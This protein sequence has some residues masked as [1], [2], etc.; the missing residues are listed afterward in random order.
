MLSLSGVIP[1]EGHVILDR[2]LVRLGAGQ[3]TLILLIQLSLVALYVSETTESQYV[4]QRLVDGVLLVDGFTSL[5][6][7]DKGLVVWIGERVIIQPE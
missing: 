1:E 5:P 3:V 4:S 7:G 6:R 2:D